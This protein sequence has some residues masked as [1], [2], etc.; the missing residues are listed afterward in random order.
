MLSFIYYIQYRAEREARVHSVVYS[1]LYK[2]ISYYIPRRAHVVIPSSVLEVFPLLVFI[3]MSVACCRPSSIGTNW[4]QALDSLRIAG[5]VYEV[6]LC[7]RQLSDILNTVDRSDRI[8]Y[9]KP[10]YEAALVDLRSTGLFLTDKVIQLIT[11]VCISYFNENL[12]D[13]I[14]EVLMQEIFMM[15]PFEEFSTIPSTCKE[16]RDLWRS[17]VVWKTQYNQRFVSAVSLNPMLGPKNAPCPYFMLYKDRLAYPYIGDGIE[18]S[19][20]GKFRLEANDIYQGLAWWR[21][22]VVG[23]STVSEDHSLETEYDAA[24]HGPRSH[25][26]KYKIH[27][28]GWESRWDEWVCRERLRWPMN[29]MNACSATISKGDTVELWCCGYNVPGAWLESTVKRIKRNRHCVTRAHVSGSVWVTRERIRP[30]KNKDRAI[31]ESDS[32][33]A[34]FNVKCYP[35]C[36]I[37]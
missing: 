14:P 5:S 22:V 8:K 20:R 27:Y 17:D 28:P 23:C 29:P 31:I 3:I 19:W 21:G 25:I 36:C 4:S 30:Q 6:A 34:A 2:F 37:M 18:V 10:D 12:L 11:T 24:Q 33:T 7:L 13:C 35:S 26:V 32:P 1:H 15:I 9:C 16:W